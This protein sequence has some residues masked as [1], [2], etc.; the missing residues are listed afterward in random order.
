MLSVKDYFNRTET[1]RSERRKLEA[2]AKQ[3]KIPSEWFPQFC[4]YAF[5]FGLALLNLR[6]FMSTVPGI[7][8]FFIGCVAI[9]SEAL[10][11]Y[12]LHNFSRSTG[13]FRLVLGCTFLALMIF[14]ITHAYFSFI[15]MIGVYELSESTHDYARHYAFPI[16]ATLIGLCT[17]AI[18]LTHPKNIVRL[19][20]AES[21]TQA[22]TA[23][24][25]AASK[26]ETLKVTSLTNAAELDYLRDKNA[27]EEEYVRELARHIEAAKGKMKLL[28]EI[29]DPALRE[30]MAHDM[31]I[32][33]KRLASSNA[34]SSPPPRTWESD[35]YSDGKDEEYSR[36][37]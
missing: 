29:P 4:K 7:R 20:Q 26:L 13:L 23:R 21:H 9:V 18:C 12:S 2:E 28:S 1:N 15:D 8:G 19:K 16:L 31:G 5:F 17:T 34:H 33:P 30:A 6:L 11:L 24:A 25:E 14:A 22:A 36:P 37:N 27:H 10:A 3:F 32:D 35:Y